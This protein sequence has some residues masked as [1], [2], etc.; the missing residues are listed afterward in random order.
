MIRK[1]LFLVLAVALVLTLGTPIVNACD[2]DAKCNIERT[3]EKSKTGIRCTIIAK[4]ETTADQVRECVRK[5]A[6]GAE[7]ADN[8][9]VTFEDIDGGIAVVKTGSDEKAVEA[10]HSKAEGCAKAAEAGKGC[11][12]KGHDAKATEG[13]DC[14]HSAGKT[15][16]HSGCCSKAKASEDA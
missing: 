13:K 8:V 7:H 9:T 5:C 6:G 11:C 3:C 2:D 10:L 14:P 16:A 15:A 12:S 1:T 4:G